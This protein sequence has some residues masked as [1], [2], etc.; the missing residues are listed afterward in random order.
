M[1]EGVAATIFCLTFNCIIHIYC[2]YDPS[3]YKLSPGVP[4]VHTSQAEFI[5]FPVSACTAMIVIQTRM[6]EPLKSLQL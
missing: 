4:T 6:L 2:G 3:P 1:G 5:S